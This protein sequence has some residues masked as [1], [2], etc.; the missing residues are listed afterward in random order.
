MKILDWG[1]HSLQSRCDLGCQGWAEANG[2]FLLFPKALE[3]VIIWVST[4]PRG[5][6]AT[7][8]TINK[9]QLKSTNLFQHH[10]TIKFPLPLGFTWVLI[11]L[12]LG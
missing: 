6:G 10:K 1:K 2:V 3:I 5:I 7:V 12:A 11:S 9:R 4:L 8:W